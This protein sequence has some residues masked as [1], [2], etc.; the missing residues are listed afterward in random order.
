MESEKTDVGHD[1]RPKITSCMAEEDDDIR[2]TPAK[3]L[4]AAIFIFALAVFVI[5]EAVQLQGTKT[6]YTHPGLLPCVTGICLILMAI[7]L[8]VRA[9]RMG[10]AKNF[11]RGKGKIALDWLKNIE[12]RRTFLLIGLVIAYVIAVDFI[13][14]DIRLFAGFYFSSYE[15][16][17]IVML[18]II[19][20]IFW[21]ATVT[22]CLLVSAGW[23]IAI[24]SVF[25]Y[26]FHILL[27]GLG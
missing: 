24:A 21:Q 4:A 25:R 16:I 7:G 12:S 11:F 27:P 13:A 22:R 23:T 26:A 18:T 17:S 19:L 9:I 15:L 6:I 10:G 5:V 3:E 14:F 20:K 1:E 8:A 2:S